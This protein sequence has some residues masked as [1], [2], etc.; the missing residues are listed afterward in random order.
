MEPVNVEK[1]RMKNSGNNFLVLD[2]F[3]F[4]FKQVQRIH[5]SIIKLV[6]WSGRCETPVG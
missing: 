4:I 2:S 6:D 1:S 3:F 5:E